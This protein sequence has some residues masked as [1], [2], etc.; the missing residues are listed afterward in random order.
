[1]EARVTTIIRRNKNCECIRFLYGLG[2][3]YCGQPIT[4]YRIRR[5]LRIHFTI[6]LANPER[7]AACIMQALSLIEATKRD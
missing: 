6:D 4:R 7:E 5:N 2:T 3:E 1:M